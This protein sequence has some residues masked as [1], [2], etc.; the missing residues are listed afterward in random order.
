MKELRG[1]ICG[2][3]LGVL[4]N[5]TPR[6]THLVKYN[7]FMYTAWHGRIFLGL[8]LYLVAAI[9]KAATFY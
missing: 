4:I 1:L 6:S 2:L 7:M 9:I 3:A 8:G 5:G